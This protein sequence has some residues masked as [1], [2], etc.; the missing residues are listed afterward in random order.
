VRRSR[1][2]RAATRTAAPKVSTEAASICSGF[3]VRQSLMGDIDTPFAGAR[4]CRNTSECVA[5]DPAAVSPLPKMDVWSIEQIR[6]VARFSWFRINVGCAQTTKSSHVCPSV[7]NN[8][9]TNISC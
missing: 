7:G 8:N 2:A 4:A 9:N 5:F 1:M 6:E 3:H